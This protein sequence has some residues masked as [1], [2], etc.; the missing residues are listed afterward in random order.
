[1]NQYCMTNDYEEKPIMSLRLF[2]NILFFALDSFIVTL[3]YIAASHIAF[4]RS[5]AKRW[6]QVFQ[7]LMEALHHNTRLLMDA[8][9][10]G[11]QTQHIRLKTYSTLRAVV[12]LSIF[13]TTPPTVTTAESRS[14][15]QHY[16]SQS[17]VSGMPWRQLRC[18]W[19]LRQL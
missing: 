13:F 5:R 12:I 2:S 8:A 19:S 1:M 7:R 4:H 9:A 6:L 15:T 14:M 10:A 18:C 3:R 16:Q 17:S 11:I